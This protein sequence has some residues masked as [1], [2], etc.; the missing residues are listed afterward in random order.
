MGKIVKS[1]TATNKAPQEN[2]LS[3]S[4]RFQTKGCQSISF[5]AEY[6]TEN[7]YSNNLTN[8]KNCPS[9]IYSL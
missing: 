2:I 6:Q 3:F 9:Q 1:Q 8:F 7:E 4:M 5:P